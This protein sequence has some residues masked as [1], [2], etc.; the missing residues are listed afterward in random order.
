M[1]ALV[2]LVGKELRHKE[3]VVEQAFLVAPLPQ[4]AVVERGQLD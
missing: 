1:E 4:V 2:G 3:I